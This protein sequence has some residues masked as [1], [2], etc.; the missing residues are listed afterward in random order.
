[1]TGLPTE[2]TGAEAQAG[3]ASALD[4]LI[5][6]Y[7]AFNAR[8]LG[9]L[10]ANWAEGDAPSMDNP[11]GGIRRGWPSI[12]EGYAKLFDGRARVEVTFHDFTSQGGGDWHLFVGREK[13]RCETPDV[14]VDLRIAGSPRSA[15]YGANFI[16][17]APLMSPHCSPPISAQ[18]SARHWKARPDRRTLSWPGLP[19]HLC[20]LLGIDWPI[21]QAPMAGTSTP[22]MAAAVSNAG[23]WALSVWARLRPEFDSVKNAAPAAL[24]EIYKSFT[25]DEAMFTTIPA[26]RPKVVSFHFGLPPKAWSRA[27]R[28]A[29]I[30]LLAPDCLRCRESTQCRCKGHRRWR[31]GWDSNP[32]WSCPHG[33]FQDRC[34]KPLG[35]PSA[36]LCAR[37][38]DTITAAI[39]QGQGMLLPW[40]RYAFRPH[41]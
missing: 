32:R 5:G 21:V 13:G 24:T 15:V 34:L 19:N 10:A 20:H 29:G 40:G 7:R 38:S 16:I 1:M 18:S 4:A 9:G 27:L 35:H 23:A 31:R 11:I 37:R 17:T 26:A 36:A 12:R 39:G 6:F 22:K 30:I 28:E 14:A 33:G 3:D 2:I 8:D 25:V 41:F